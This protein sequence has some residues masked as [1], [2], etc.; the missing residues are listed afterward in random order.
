M[1]FLTVLLFP[2]YEINAPAAAGMDRFGAAVVQD[3]FVRATSIH[4]C[5]TKNWHSVEGT[6]LV[7]A[8]SESEDG[9][10]EPRSG[11]GYGAEGVAED[12]TQY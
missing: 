6:V 8:L 10:G 12:V 11:E 4:E 1:N 9:G 3:V 2:E 5:I 7:D